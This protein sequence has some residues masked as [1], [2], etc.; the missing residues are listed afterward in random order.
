MKRGYLYLIFMTLSAAVVL[1]LALV[2]KLTTTAE[3]SKTSIS[4][5]DSDTNSLQSAMKVQNYDDSW[6]QRLSREKNQKE[7]L[8]PTQK[9][10]IEFN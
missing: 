3:M 4:I 7:Y 2:F 5:T 6:I 9:F 8:Y 10:H 1:M